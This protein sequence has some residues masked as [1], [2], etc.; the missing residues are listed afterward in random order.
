M[1]SEIRQQLEAQ[2]GSDCYELWFGAPQA[3][4]VDRGTLVI[5]MMD[6]FSMDR[7]HSTYSSVIK[8]LAGRA[9]IQEINYEVSTPTQ[10]TLNVVQD[11]EATPSIDT[12]VQDTGEQNTGSHHSGEQNTDAGLRNSTDEKASLQNSVNISLGSKSAGNSMAVA[13]APN[14]GPVG[15]NSR[16]RKPN[17]VAKGK[18]GHSLAEFVVD[19]QNDLVWK[20]SLQV[21]KSPGDLTPFFIYGPSGSGK[22]HLL[23]GIRAE[24][25]KRSRTGK[26][27]YV[28]SEQFT[29]DFVGSLKARSMPMFRKRYREL[30]FLI[31]DDIHFLAGKQSTLVELQH[32]IEAVIKRGGQVI[33]AADRTPNELEF[34]GPEFVN[35][36]ASG[37]VTQLHAPGAEAK[38]EIVRQMAAKRGIELLQE[39]IEFIAEEIVGDVRLLSGAINKIKV[40][41]YISDTPVNA[42]EARRILA[43]LVHVSRKTVSLCE[44]ENAVCDLFGLDQKSLRSHSKVKTV[45]QPRMLAMWLSRKYTRAALSEIGDHFGGR[46][47]ST[48][49]SAQ[50]KVEKWMADGNMIGLNHSEFPVE[51]AIRRIEQVLRVG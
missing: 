41:Q 46:S 13:K 2:I 17:S 39:T 30:D 5:T 47:H 27:Q 32:T 10:L 45:S 9:G 38:V 35:R 12:G 25:R 49:I 24:A 11:D 1:V 20:A 21:L 4:T 23:E 31:V 22:T 7:I 3:I 42:T 18:N 28:T 51:K 8:S 19:P 26:I 29:S 16:P 50:S 44:I 6:Q 40:H 36:I 15:D 34:A 14:G 37:L 43:D 33:M 48:V